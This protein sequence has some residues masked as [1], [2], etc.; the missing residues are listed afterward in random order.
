M[1][2]WSIPTFHLPIFDNGRALVHRME[3]EYGRAM[4]TAKKTGN[5]LS[6]AAFIR[7]FPT[8]MPAKDVVAKAKEKGISLTAN[9]VSAVRST[10]RGKSGKRPA[11]KAAAPKAGGAKPAAKGA[12]S[13]A[14][15]VRS[16][17]RSTPAK[18]V[19]AKAKAAGLKL[20]SEYVYKVRSKGGGKAAPAKRG[21]GR[22]ASAPVA[23]R[24]HA[25]GIE[26]QLALLLVE[27][28]LDRVQRLVSEIHG[29]LLRSLA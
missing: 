1:G 15:F 3:M 29:R 8:A 25:N 7:Q 11:A 16:L 27:H 20:N 18:D 6:K 2:G 24:P 13:K 5:K 4:A 10:S 28:G 21:P 19:V 22:P 14:A 23:T 12:V 9:H 26:Q 17:P